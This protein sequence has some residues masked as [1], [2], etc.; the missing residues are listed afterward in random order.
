M[1]WVSVKKGVPADFKDMCGKDAVLVYSEISGPGCHGIA[2]YVGGKWEVLGN[3]GAHSCTGFYHMD[4]NDITHWKRL[5]CPD[6][7]SEKGLR[8]SS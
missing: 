7:E 1:K 5:D 3:E 2:R 4:S 8:D 6:E